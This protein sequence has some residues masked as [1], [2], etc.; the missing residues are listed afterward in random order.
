M[1]PVEDLSLDAVRRNP[2]AVEG[3]GLVI[4]QHQRSACRTLQTHVEHSPLLFLS[5]STDAS[6]VEP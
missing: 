1:L 6:V 3:A 4:T 2:P 5:M